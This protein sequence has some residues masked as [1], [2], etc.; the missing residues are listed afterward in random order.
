MGYFPPSDTPVKVLPRA[1]RGTLPHE[2]G[3]RSPPFWAKHLAGAIGSAFPIAGASA[4]PMLHCKKK[5]ERRCKNV[6]AASSQSTNYQISAANGSLRCSDCHH[7][8][9]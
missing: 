5:S 9:H 1:P 8:E 6:S 3:G 7:S 2:K 4:G